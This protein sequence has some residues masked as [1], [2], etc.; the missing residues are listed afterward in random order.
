MFDINT[1]IVLLPG[2][3]NQASKGV[4]RRNTITRNGAS[5]YYLMANILKPIIMTEEDEKDGKTKKL[6]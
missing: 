2:V 6:Y 1:S 4:S 5:F 3:D